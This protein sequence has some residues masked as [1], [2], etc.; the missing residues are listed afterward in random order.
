[1][2]DTLIQ[3]MQALKHEIGNGQLAYLFHAS[4]AKI[5]REIIRIS[6]RPG[7][8]IEALN[9]LVTSFTDSLIYSNENASE[10]LFNKQKHVFIGRITSRIQALSEAKKMM[11]AVSAASFASATQTFISHSQRR[12]VSPPS[13]SKRVTHVDKSFVDD[14]FNTPLFL[15]LSDPERTGLSTIFAAIRDI[16]KANDHQAIAALGFIFAEDIIDVLR[17]ARYSRNA[18]EIFHA[19]MI[20]IQPEAQQAEHYLLSELIDCFIKNLMSVMDFSQTSSASASS[21]NSM[22]LFAQMPSE[23]LTVINDIQL[24]DKRVF[25]DWLQPLID[26]KTIFSVPSQ[27][28]VNEDG[29]VSDEETNYSAKYLNF[30]ITRLT[31]I[32]ERRIACEL[33]ESGM[34][35]DL[36]FAILNDF[37]STL[38]ECTDENQSILIE[39]EIFG[40]SYNSAV[41]DA[42]M[43]FNLRFQRPPEWHMKSDAV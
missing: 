4:V 35:D 19:R 27:A 34:L 43:E 22:G 12:T 2:F 1:M 42:L 9:E 36:M 11:P 18:I 31:A 8:S 26:L 33:H 7:F 30:L 14:F 13:K 20:T 40:A 3:L 5:E 24:L 37:Y 28:A 15:P 10:P 39:T 6:Q 16:L 23:K 21:L 25:D 32:Y 29:S 38:P 17:E 41:A